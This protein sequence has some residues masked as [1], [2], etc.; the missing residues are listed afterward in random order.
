MKKIKNE[1]ALFKSAIAAGAKYGEERGAVEFDQG[2]TLNEKAQYIYRLLVHDKLL[3]PLPEEQV[4]QK[5]IRHRLV[6]WHMR[7]LPKDDPL[8]S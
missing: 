5:S 6:L 1:S 4:S 3:A 8:L 2:D 7:Q